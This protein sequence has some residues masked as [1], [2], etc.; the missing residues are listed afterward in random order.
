MVLGTLMSWLPGWGQTDDAGE[1]VD[2]SQREI[3]EQVFKLERQMNRIGADVDKRKSTYIEYLKKGAEAP[4]GEQKVFAIRARLEK[5]K[6][7]IQ[8]LERLRSMKELAKWTTVQGQ[9]ELQQMM[10]DIDSSVDLNELI[11]IDLSEFEGKIDD[12]QHD[13]QFGME[14]VS[15]I[16]DETDVDV[17]DISVN[18]GEE[19]ALMNQMG[20]GTLDVEDV[21][22]DLNL[23]QTEDEGGLLDELS[24]EDE[25]A[26]PRG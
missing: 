23:M 19:E 5:F 21:D 2:L 16:M 9:T 17:G 24:L 11:D 18:L 7:H 15:S 8:E 1:T 6:F 4:P 3:D 13:I 26:D 25:P 10:D 12:L 20:Q 22:L 14:E